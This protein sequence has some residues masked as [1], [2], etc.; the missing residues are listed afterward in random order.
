[1]RYNLSFINEIIR[2]FIV[3]RTIHF[4]QRTIDTRSTIKASEE[5]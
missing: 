3:K 1:M 4:L 5:I 2:R